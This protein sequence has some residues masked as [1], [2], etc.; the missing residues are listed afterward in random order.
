LTE[1]LNRTDRD[2]L[3]AA[4]MLLA[5]ELV[6]FGTETVYGL[7]ADATNAAA[8]A[9]VFEA[10]GRPRFNPLICHYETAEAAFADVVASPLAERLADTFWPGPLTMVLPRRA[11]CNVALLAGAGLETL[12]VRV[13][14]HPVA[15]RLISAVGRPVAAPSANRS[16][17]ISPTTA[18]HVLA[19]LEGRIAAVIDSG[20]CR[21]GLESTVVDLSGPVP[22]L[23]R[24][25]G[26][27]LESLQASVGSLQKVRADGLDGIVRGPGMLAAHY[28]P[29][30]P[31][32]IDAAEVGGDEAL[33]AFGP[34][35]PGAGVVFQLSATEN[36]NEAAARLFEGLHWLDAQA[37]AQ[38][39]AGIAAMAVPNHGLGLAINDRLARAAAA[40][41]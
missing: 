3:R 33:L 9:G 39:L 28:A 15:Q 29:K 34:A 20:P 23:L 40:A 32:R 19:G 24:P 5:G 35:L 27:S 14:A 31:L 30:L 21:V 36:L 10:K 12:A 8:V 2:I 41:H 17:W 25:G 37:A 16:G 13:P 6:A 38:S 4:A 7:G 26:V 1:I 22:V 11:N 18:A